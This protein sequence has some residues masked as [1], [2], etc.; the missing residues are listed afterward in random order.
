MTGNC[1]CHGSPA[2]HSRA[3]A[4]T[5]ERP[6]YSTGLILEESDLTSAVEYTRSLSRLLARNMFGCGVICGLEVTMGADCGLIVNVA[7]G[8]ALDGCGDPVEVPAPIALEL[9][10]SEVVRLFNPP[11]KAEFW[12]V[13][14]GGE[15]LCA[16]RAVPCESGGYDEVAQPTRIR[17]LAVV[18]LAFEKPECLC[19]SRPAALPG[20]KPRVGCAPGSGCGTACARGCCLLLAHVVGKPGANGEIT[21]TVGEV[22]DGGGSSGTNHTSASGLFIWQS[23]MILDVNASFG[24]TTEPLGPVFGIGGGP[25]AALKSSL[26]LLPLHRKAELK[27]ISLLRFPEPASNATPY[28]PAIQFD[29]VIM[30]YEGALIRKISTATLNYKAIPLKDWTPIALSAVPGDLEVM[31]GEVIAGQLT[32]D[33]PRPNSSN[34]YT[35]FQLSGT[36]ILL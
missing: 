29:L 7:P 30:D 14:C 23:G 19:E 10:E 35:Q 15:K 22:G 2:E 26:C 34:F 3:V 24:T 5:L 21:W 9:E 4:A 1:S 20:G 33:T 27:E 6:R 32:F 31:P 13:L 16:P 25:N 18:S 11:G 28:N 17:S 12:V 36:G 8:L